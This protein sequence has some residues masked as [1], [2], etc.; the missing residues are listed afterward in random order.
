MSK[1]IIVGREGGGAEII[2]TDKIEKIYIEMPEANALV[3]CFHDKVKDEHRQYRFEYPHK[4]GETG[5]AIWPFKGYAKILESTKWEIDLENILDETRRNLYG[6]NKH[7][8][9]QS[10]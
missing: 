5:A 10:E 6:V 7:V 8:G 9:E 1:F 3:V 4:E 2:N